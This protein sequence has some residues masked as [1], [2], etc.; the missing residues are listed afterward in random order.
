MC[1]Q[2]PSHSIGCQFCRPIRAQTCS[3][4]PQREEA[5]SSER[6]S[7]VRTPS[8]FSPFAT[9]ERGG[10]YPPHPK[11]DPK[12]L[13]LNLKIWGEN[14]FLA[15]IRIILADC[16]WSAADQWLKPFHLPRAPAV[17]RNANT[18]IDR[19]VERNEDFLNLK[20]KG[21]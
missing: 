18:E 4:L 1:F 6:G 15:Q 20:K 17:G 7:G 14:Q 10:P 21:I 3:A 13:W 2:C 8:F 16:E 5:Q 19:D 12:V 9:V 11:K